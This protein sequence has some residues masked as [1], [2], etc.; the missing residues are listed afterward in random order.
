MKLKKRDLSSSCGLYACIA[1]QP[2][3]AGLCQQH[4]EILASVAMEMT[5]DPCRYLFKYGELANRLYLILEGSVEL[6]FEYNGEKDIPVITLG[7]GD[8]LGW[9]WLFE[10]HYFR[11]R[12]RVVT[13]TRTIFFYGTR[14]RD[15]CEQNRDFGVE[16]MQRVD[17][18]AIQRLAAFQQTR[19]LS[20]RT[21]ITALPVPT[22]SLHNRSANVYENQS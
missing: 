9:S 6:K 5:F 10:P 12:A 7:P 2:F 20:R 22:V 19:A 4:L 1:G 11:G 17:R 8:V 15:Q 21:S 16:I 18:A 14:L 3:F 13:P